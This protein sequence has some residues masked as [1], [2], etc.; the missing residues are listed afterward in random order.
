MADADLCEYQKRYHYR[1]AFIMSPKLGHSMI[2]VECISDGII[3]LRALGE[4]NL[5]VCTRKR[6]KKGGYYSMAKCELR[7][8]EGKSKSEIFELLDKKTDA[9]SKKH[10]GE[11]VLEDRIGGSN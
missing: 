2:K 4:G 5:L 10:D 7:E 6:P 8:L 11:Y 1:E 3:V 9:L